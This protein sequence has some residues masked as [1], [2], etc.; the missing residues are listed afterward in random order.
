VFWLAIR[1]LQIFS[2]NLKYKYFLLS[3]MAE[4]R[5]ILG[6]LVWILVTAIASW[7]GISLTSGFPAAMIIATA[8]FLTVD[9][10]RYLKVNEKMVFSL[11][12]SA[13]GFALFAAAFEVLKMGVSAFAGVVTYVNYLVSLGYVLSWIC[14]VLAAIVLAMSA[15]K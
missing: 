7:A 10:L 13:A 9:V 2:L 5:G 1:Q 8:F 12:M 11:F 6:L 4:V 3:I 15:F 14:A